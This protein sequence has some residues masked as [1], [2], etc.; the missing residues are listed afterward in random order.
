MATTS[1]KPETNA[2]VGSDP[3]SHAASLPD[4]DAVPN[5]NVVIYDGNCNFCK[6][7]VRRLA[8]F[9]KGRLSFVSLHDER[10]AERFPDLSHDQMMEQMFVVTPEG[11]R[12]GGAQA[13][14]TLSRRLPWLW[15]AAPLMHIPFSM[16]L[17]QFLYRQ[18]AQSRYQI[19]GSC[20]GDSCKVHFDK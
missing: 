2:T 12:F 13:I 14:R 11:E 9:G 17:W 3:S 7:Q 1:E 6:A 5:A 18:I 20:D 10:V 16:P 15:L 4:M 19:A 8:W